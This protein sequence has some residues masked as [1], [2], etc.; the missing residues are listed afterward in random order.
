MGT[1]NNP[2]EFD[3]CKAAEPD[4]PTFVLL[5]RD[6]AA[7][8]LVMAWAAIR[9][10]N[11]DDAFLSLRAAMADMAKS[12]KDYSYSFSE[13]VN[14]AKRCAQEME[15]WRKA[16]RPDRTRK[17]MTKFRVECWTL[18]FPDNEE[19]CENEIVEEK[20][21]SDVNEAMLWAWNK[22]EEGFFVRMFRR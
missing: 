16:N 10:G 11:N 20:D 3:C 7:A 14:D 19:P 22:Q 5:A 2:G 1:K 18:N 13:K 21:F 4:E 6:P 17:K 15:V 8:N 9:S 12:G